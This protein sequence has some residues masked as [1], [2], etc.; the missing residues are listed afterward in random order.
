MDSVRG[1]ASRFE[2]VIYCVANRLGV[3]SG[4]GYLDFRERDSILEHGHRSS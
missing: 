3:A 1:D 4:V 2:R